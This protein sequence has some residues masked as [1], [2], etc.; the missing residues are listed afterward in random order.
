VYC[1]LRL[2]QGFTVSNRGE[3]KGGEI[4]A[5]QGTK[6]KKKKKKKNFNFLAWKISL[7]PTKKDADKTT[8]V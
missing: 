8:A 4:N 6:E 7:V 5:L 1:P 2:P 3:K